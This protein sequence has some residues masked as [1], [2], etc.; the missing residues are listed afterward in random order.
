MPDEVVR[1]IRKL[2]APDQTTKMEL[3]AMA[4]LVH[5]KNNDFGYVENSDLDTLIERDVIYAYKTPTGWVQVHR[6][7]H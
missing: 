6:E 7:S 5:F 4:I 2:T 1:I 3:D